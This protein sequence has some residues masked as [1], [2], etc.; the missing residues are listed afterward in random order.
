MSN[1]NMW[2]LLEK[3]ESEHIKLALTLKNGRKMT[4]VV[5]MT[6]WSNDSD[7]GEDEVFFDT[8]D[9]EQLFFLADIIEDV[10]PVEG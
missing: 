5:F 8:S 9:G 1:S 3:S 2:D 7:S 4:G 6:D 10:R